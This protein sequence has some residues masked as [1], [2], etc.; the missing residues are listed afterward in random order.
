[1]VAGGLVTL[2][3]I[4]PDERVEGGVTWGTLGDTDFVLLLWRRM[5]ELRTCYRGVATSMGG[6][7][8][9]GVVYSVCFCLVLSECD[10][11]TFL[12]RL[13]FLHIE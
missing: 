7:G 6:L 12:G 1:M 2:D 10:E 8:G 5:G 4:Y 13:C 11:W 9:D 3:P